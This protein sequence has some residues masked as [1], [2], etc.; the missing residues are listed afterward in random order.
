MWCNLQKHLKVCA[1]VENQRA[2]PEMKREVTAMLP[3]TDVNAQQM[4]M[5]AQMDK[6]VSMKNAKVFQINTLN[7]GAYIVDDYVL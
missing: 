2:V 6:N 3:R 4:Q 1:N 7:P 5:L